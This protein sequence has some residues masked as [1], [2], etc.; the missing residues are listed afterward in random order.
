MRIT[1]F[2]RINITLP[3]DTLRLLDRLA[4]KGDRSKF[5]KEAVHAYVET[6]GRER[7]KAELKAGAKA[8]ALRDLALTAEW[9]QID[10]E[11][12]PGRRK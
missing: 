2:K 11:T 8:R 9:F 7:L 10:Q 5:I 3:E 4:P 1:A 12:W 6:R